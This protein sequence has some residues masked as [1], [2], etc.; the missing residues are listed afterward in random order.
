MDTPTD[1]PNSTD[2]SN[3]RVEPLGAPPSQRHVTVTITARTLWLAAAITVTL[4]ALWLLISHA[5]DSLVLLFIAIVIGEAIRPLVAHIERWRIPRPLGVVLVFLA[6]LVV[7]GGLMWLLVNPLVSQLGTFSANAPIYV[8]RL[9]RLVT[10]L[11]Q[12]LHTNSLVG[13]AIDA[14][15]SNVAST[16]QRTFPALLSLPLN[17]VTGGVG[18]LFSLVIVLTVTVFWLMSSH[19]LG[20]FVLSLFPISSRPQVK[21]VMDEVGRSLGGYVRGVLFAMFLIGVLTGIGLAILGVPYAL[22]LALLA[23]LTEFIPY[24]GPWISG[25]VAV[26]VALVTVDPLKAVEVIILFIV[27]QQVEGNLVQPLVMSK[28]VNLDPLLVLIAITI[29]VQLLG[30]V[31]AILA[32]PLVAAMQVLVVRVIAPA[33]RRASATWVPAPSV[34]DNPALPVSDN[35]E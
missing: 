1:V 22:P 10:T 8:T 17:I 27:V 9:Q 18:L 30:I 25:T 3:S 32:V 5:M 6:V 20:T 28:A 21:D 14:L 7:F 15:S 4:L 31:G 11:S 16:L 33:I 26:L 19:R 29:G 13:Q 24:L 12:A 35:A 23:G 2:V 34:P